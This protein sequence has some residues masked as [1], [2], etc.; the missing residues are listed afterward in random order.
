[1]KNVV[2]NENCLTEVQLLRYLHDECSASEEKAIDS[3]LTHCPMCSDAL[4]GA[5]LLNTNRLERSLKHLDAK[6]DTH[7]ADK[8]PIA[9]G[10]KPIMTV[11]K[12]P[13]KRGWMWAA[14]GIA[15]VATASVMVL[16][17]PL[18]DEKALPTVASADTVSSTLPL[19][20]QVDSTGQNS[21]AQADGL[22]KMSSTSQSG[23]PSD[24]KSGD[25]SASDVATADN[26]V[27]S[28]KDAPKS[29]GATTTNAPVADAET[30]TTNK[31]TP[32]KQAETPK[33]D[34]NT[35]GV[36]VVK[37]VLEKERAKD[38]VKM[39]DVAV[40]NANKNTR[41]VEKK[42][43][44]QAS[45]PVPS[46]VDN[47][48]G[49]AAQNTYS[50]PAAKAKQ[51]AD[52]GVAMYQLAMQTYKK[53]AYNEAIGQLNRVLATQSSG[54]VYENALWYLADSYLQLGNKKEGRAILQRIVNEKGKY[55]QRA[56]ALLK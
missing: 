33:T 34:K 1:M 7:Y 46:S 25:F 41:S 35:E 47:Y 16:T 17:Q 55:A 39:K 15:V 6:I 10:E 40:A 21:V 54:D 22:K 13:K 24:T 19:A 52:N 50:S 36:A 23:I 44:Q 56:L 20:I 43:N 9:V 27:Q 32:S 37:E 30:A 28:E 42:S 3:H 38:E 11:V 49:A 8:T 18:T 31:P 14:A 5:M 12:S 51:P 53:G 29:F 2:P 45:A 48:P 26:N 4:E